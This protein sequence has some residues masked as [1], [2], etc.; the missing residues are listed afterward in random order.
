MHR[1]RVQAY[2]Q[3][4]PVGRIHGTFGEGCVNQSG[5]RQISRGGVVKLEHTWVMEESLGRELFDDENVHHVNG[6][7]LDNRLENLE[8]W[9]TKQPPGQRVQDKVQFA[10]EFVQRYQP[11]YLR[12]NYDG[13]SR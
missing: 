11:E 8:L 4:G 3:P 13:A 10:L 12:D 6:D 2:G 7:R 1:Q 9:S 5:Y